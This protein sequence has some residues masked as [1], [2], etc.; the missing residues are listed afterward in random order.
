MKFST[1]LEQISGVS[2]Y[3]VVSL[4]MFVIF[5][6]GVTYWMLSIDAKEIERFEKL[7]LDD[8]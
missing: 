7:P 3:P 2:I 8:K 4:V 5:F 6:A 1:Y